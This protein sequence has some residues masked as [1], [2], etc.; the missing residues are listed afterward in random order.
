MSLPAA[1]VDHIFAKLTLTYGQRFMGL[2]AGLDIADVKADW[3]RVLSAFQQNRA[4][5]SFG[6]E[7]LP[8][9]Q[10][11]TA[12]QFRAICG[13]RPDA[14]V[15]R[16]PAPECSAEAKSQGVAALRHLMGKLG[17]RRFGFEGDGVAWA[18][19]LQQREQGG[20]NLTPFQ[21]DAWREALRQPIVQ[22]TTE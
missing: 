22:E 16:L 17:K 14:P 20:D 6:L 21:R 3:G 12:L 19:R 18:L 5:L 10:P 9:D 2:Y 11:P 8:A 13:R 4:A 7:N 1:W 15:Q